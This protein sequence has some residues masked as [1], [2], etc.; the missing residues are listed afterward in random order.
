MKYYPFP[1]NKDIFSIAKFDQMVIPGISDF[2]TQV[3]IHNKSY[4]K[5]ERTKSEI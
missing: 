3:S 1:F 4:K 2:L 5:Q